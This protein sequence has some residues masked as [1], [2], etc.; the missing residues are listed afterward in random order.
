MSGIDQKGVI[1]A[2][3]AQI[4]RDHPKAISRLEAMHRL[5]SKRE[6]D[7]AS[8]PPEPVKPGETI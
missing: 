3:I 2:E 4:M 7:A 5:I 1:D 6:D 8:P